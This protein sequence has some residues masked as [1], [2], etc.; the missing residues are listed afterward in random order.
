MQVCFLAEVT[1][2]SAGFGALAAC[3]DAE[4]M[5]GAAAAKSAAGAVCAPERT[6]LSD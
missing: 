5:A 3:I 4:V 2:S 1:N 6:I